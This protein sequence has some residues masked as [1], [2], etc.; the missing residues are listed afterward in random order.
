VVS[1]QGGGASGRAKVGEETHKLWR[2]LGHFNAQSNDISSPQKKILT[3]VC[4]KARE[5]PK[6]SER[7]LQKMK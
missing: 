7:E 1:G 5:K 6:L 2:I 3:G 4:A